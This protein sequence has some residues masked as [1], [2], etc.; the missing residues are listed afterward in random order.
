MPR[1]EVPLT[2]ERP[3]SWAKGWGYRL[4]LRGGTP[5]YDILK[6]VL[7]V[8]VSVVALILF[9]PLVPFI[10]LAIVLDSPGP[11]F[12]CQERIG[13]G[14]RPFCVYKF[15]SMVANADPTSIASTFGG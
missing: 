11:V 7:D 12:F 15:R 10:A 8:L 13:K 5:L 2:V 14:G 9:L 6:R 4:S 3:S 1:T